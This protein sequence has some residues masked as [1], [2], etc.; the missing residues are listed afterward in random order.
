MQINVIAIFTGKYKLFFQSLYESSEKYFLP[1]YSKKYY[2]FS[3]GDI[4][5]HSNVA[6]IEQ[7]KL[8][9]PYDTMMR[10]H[11][12]NKLSL[13]ENAYIF[14]LNANMLFVN[15]VDTEV[16]PQ[17]EHDFL[18][19]VKHPGFYNKNVE[20]YPYEKRQSSSFYIPKGDGKFY[21]QGCFNGGR[22][23]EFL[24]M[25]KELSILIDKDV[26]NSI[27]PRWHDESALNW[28]YKS[29]NPLALNPEYAYPES[30]E[31]AFS[32][33]IIQLDKNNY[34]GHDYLRSF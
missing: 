27:I 21:F 12:F 2:V 25:S 3:D 32:K 18:M 29:K 17:K 7:E 14:F 5:T 4:S 20:S 26:K 16:L 33:K 10:F 23:K 28:Y 34:G 19:G 13:D 15:T 6:K 24:E 31:N 22:V 9:W 11:M 8:G 30:W 1:Q